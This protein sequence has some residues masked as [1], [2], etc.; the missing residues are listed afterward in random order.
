MVIKNKVTRITVMTY[1]PLLVQAQ[2]V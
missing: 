1:P 2:T